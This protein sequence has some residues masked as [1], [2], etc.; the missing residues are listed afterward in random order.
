MILYATVT[1]VADPKLKFRIRL[2]IR[3]RPAVSFESDPDSNPDS[4]PG[5]GSGSESWIRIHIRNWPKLLLFFSFTQP[6]LQT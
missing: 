2:W 6:H 5:F 1:S 4:N 3:I